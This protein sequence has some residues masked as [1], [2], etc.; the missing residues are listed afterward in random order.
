MADEG[1]NVPQPP[2]YAAE[3]AQLLRQRLMDDLNITEEEAIQ[4]L[5]DLWLN[6]QQRRRQ[7]ERAPEH[8]PQDGDRNRP[9][10]NDDHQQDPPLAT[11]KKKPVRI[12]KG[13]MVTDKRIPDPSD[14]ALRKLQNYEYVELWYF[15]SRGC[16]EAA[17]SNLSTDMESLSITRVDNTL[18]LQPSRAVAHAKGVIPDQDLSWLEMSAAKNNMLSHMAKCGWDKDTVAAFLEFYI[19]LDLHSTRGEEHAEQVLLAYQAE[20]RRDWHQ[21][22]ARLGRGHTVFDISVINES[23]LRSI[24]E[25]LHRKR[26]NQAIAE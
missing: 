26:R 21:E 12:T 23:R 16:T 20:I 18:E 5:N 1:E 25:E 19:A 24:S 9:P 11:P 17:R 10:A 8:P 2:N 4:Q 3:D 6:A 14:Y 22:V 7:Q 15:S 13:L